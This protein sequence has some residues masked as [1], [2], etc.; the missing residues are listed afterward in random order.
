M[1]TVWK[2]MV[3]EWQMSNVGE[4][5]T[6]KQFPAVFRKTWNRVAT[7][8]NASHGFR[9]AG[10]YPL[11]SEG[12]DMSKLGPSRMTVSSKD[13][14]P[15]PL[16]TSTQSS[17]CDPCVSGFS[18]NPD[19]IEASEIVVSQSTEFE[20]QLL[21]SPDIASTDDVNHPLQ[22]PAGS[23]DGASPSNSTERL[24]QLVPLPDISYTDSQANTQP[25]PLQAIYT[26]VNI[27]LPSDPTIL[28]C[29]PCFLNS[30][31]PNQRFVSRETLCGINS[32]K[33]YL[34]RKP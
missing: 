8:E 25:M 15:S 3:K 31:F 16:V 12:I 17:P 11:S 23:P 34:G 27:V 7:L 21:A 19:I 6:K 2:A 5:L 4:V 1:K 20:A 14:A 22:S 32:R 30:V 10:L 26:D 24:I 29:L 13:S 18:I 9:R 33:H 28:M